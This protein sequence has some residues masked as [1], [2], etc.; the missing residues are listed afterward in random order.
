MPTKL[1]P[2]D[3]ISN[4]F[5]MYQAICASIAQFS[6]VQVTLVHVHGHLETCNPKCLLM[7]TKMLNIEC[8]KQGNQH[9]NITQPILNNS[10]PSITNSIPHLWF[11][12]KI[13]Y[14]HSHPP[15][16]RQLQQQNIL[17]IF[18]RNSSRNLNPPQLIHWQA[19]RC[20]N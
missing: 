14:Q 20:T 10:N 2:C 12:N 6:P 4:Y 19:C 13:I 15:Y 16:K 17:S 11:N 7:V 9:A 8:N 18:M 1:H 3:M 5:L